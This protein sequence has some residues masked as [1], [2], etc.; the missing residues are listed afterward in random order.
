MFDLNAYRKKCSELRLSEETLQ[1]VLSMT[2]QIKQTNSRRPLRVGLIAAALCALLAISV[3]AANP[4]VLEGLV[5]TIRSSTTV[6]EYRE[7]LVMEGGEQITALRFPEATVEERD[8]RTVLT[9]DGQE[10]DITDAM[11]QDGTYTWTYED[12]GATVSVKVYLD[13]NGTLQTVTN[14][15]PAEGTQESGMSIIGECSSETPEE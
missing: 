5:T 8:G 7:N 14:V 15:A 2:E 3:S 4:Q 9:V 11:A 13:E 12:E 1:E 6:G 10:M